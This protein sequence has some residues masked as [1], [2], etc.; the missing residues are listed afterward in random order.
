MKTIPIIAT[1]LLALPIS[2]RA[3]EQRCGG[4]IADWQPRSALVKMAEDMGWTVSRIRADDGCYMIR[5]RDK[6]GREIRARIDPVSLKVLSTR[7][8]RRHH[9]DDDDEG[10]GQDRRDGRRGER[11]QA[12]TKSR[13]PAAD[14]PLM[15]GKPQSQI[16]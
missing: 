10:R 8:G 6:E 15:M 1:V 5:G 9:D 4:V 13:A 7:E 3:E 14:N 2:A 16:Q 11:Q 12:P